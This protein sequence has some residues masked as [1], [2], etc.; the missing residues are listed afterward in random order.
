MREDVDENQKKKKG[1][2]MVEDKKIHYVC[3]DGITNILL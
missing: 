3:P 2:D 1:V